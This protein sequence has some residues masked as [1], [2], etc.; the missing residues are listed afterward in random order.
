MNGILACRQWMSAG[1]PTGVSVDGRG[2]GPINRELKPDAGNG[3]SVYAAKCAS[4]HGAEGAGMART[5]VA[6][7][8]VKYNMAPRPTS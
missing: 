6:A 5:Y 3:I 8:F 7:A 2:F 1:V 4:C